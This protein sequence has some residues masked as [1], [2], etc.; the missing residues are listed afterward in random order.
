MRKRNPKKEVVP[1]SENILSNALITTIKDITITGSY[2][3]MTVVLLISLIILVPISVRVANKAEQEKR[4]AVTPVS[5]PKQ[6][7]TDNGFLVKPLEWERGV[8]SYVHPSLEGNKTASGVIFKNDSNMLA[9]KELPH[10]AIILLKYKGRYAV[11]EVVDRGPFVDGR[12]FDASL[13]IANQL[14]MIED[15]VARGIEYSILYKPSRR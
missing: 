5:E 1:H 12:D 10:G 6:P 11:G 13:K 4:Q 14:G 3:P 7:E 2:I 15:G 9:H 8:S